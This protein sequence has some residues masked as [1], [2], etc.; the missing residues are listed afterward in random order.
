MA[1]RVWLPKLTTIHLY[2]LPNLQK[3]CEVKMLA[4]AL[5][6]IRIR[7]F[8]GLRQLPAVIQARGGRQ[9]RWTCGVRWSGTD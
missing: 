5:E 8:F 1:G 4:P 9:W 2:D 3:I 7:R 6:T